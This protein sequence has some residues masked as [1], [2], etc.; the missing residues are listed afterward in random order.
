MPSTPKPT[1]IRSFLE[2]RKQTSSSTLG[3]PQGTVLGP[4]LFL[5]YIND[6]SETATSSETKLFADGHDSLLYRTINNQ[7]DSD[8]LQRDLAT[9]E[10]WE[11]KWQ[12]S[13]NANKCIVIRIVSKTKRWGKQVTNYMD[14][15]WTMRKPAN[16]NNNLSWDRLIDNIVGKGN[17]TLGFICRNLKDCTKPVKS[18]AYKCIQQWLGR[19]WNIKPKK[20]QIHRTGTEKSSEICA[21][22]LHRPN[23]AVSQNMVNSLKWENLEDRRKSARLCTLFKF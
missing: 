22:Q 15:L 17:K 16:I 12:M 21:Q 11:N 4:L 14:I 3:V 18:A 10:D 8:L 20:D 19:Q 7:T 9:R 1:W 23:K 2:N 6:M 13:F 5:A